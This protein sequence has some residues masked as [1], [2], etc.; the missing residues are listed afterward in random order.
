MNFFT[1]SICGCM[2]IK[3]DAQDRE[4][5]HHYK[6]TWLLQLIHLLLYLLLRN[7]QQRGSLTAWVHRMPLKALLGFIFFVNF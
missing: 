3:L 4:H 7:G 5:H 1:M 6:I 2:Q